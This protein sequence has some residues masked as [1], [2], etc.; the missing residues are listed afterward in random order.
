MD[1]LRMMNIK[2]ES[3]SPFEKGRVR[4]I[5]TGEFKRG[6]APLPE[7][8]PSPFKERGTQGVR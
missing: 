6:C 8:S 2:E 5:L 1:W 4:G 7:T 3:S